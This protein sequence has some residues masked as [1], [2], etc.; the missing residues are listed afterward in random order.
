MTRAQS[1]I[2][3]LMVT[4]IGLLLLTTV[5]AGYLQYQRGNEDRVQ[6]EQAYAIGTNILEKVQFVYALGGSSWETITVTMPDNVVD[7]YAVENNTLGFTLATSSG[8]TNQLLI[9]DIPING[10]RTV[11]G[12]SSIYNGS[13]TIHGGTTKIRITSQGSLVQ[14]QAI[15]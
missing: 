8:L 4:G 7:V 13:I 5:V 15:A 2:E 6:V 9:S 12:H 14:I 3:F 1:S 10:T 11:N